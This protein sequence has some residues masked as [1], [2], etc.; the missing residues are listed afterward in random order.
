MIAHFRPLERVK[1]MLI[2]KEL[3]NE[4]LLCGI[5]RKFDI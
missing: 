5:C 4:M 1:N 2:L 3:L